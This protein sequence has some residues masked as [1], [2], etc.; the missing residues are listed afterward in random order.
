[1]PN[2]RLNPLV[3]ARQR[4]KRLVRPVGLRSPRSSFA[5]A[6]GNPARSIPRIVSP[7]LRVVSNNNNE[8]RHLTLG[9]CVGAATR[10]DLAAA[11]YVRVHLSPLQAEDGG[12]LPQNATRRPE[13]GF[14]A[15]L[16][17]PWDLTGYREPNAGHQPSSDQPDGRQ[18]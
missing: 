6:A 5:E 9:V 18:P 10:E 4:A 15:P 7:Q 17:V 13:F 2:P 8:Y 12:L 1:M 14:R 3:A 11:S 16:P